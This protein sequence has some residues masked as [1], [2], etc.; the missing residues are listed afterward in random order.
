MTPEERLGAAGF[1]LPAAH[2]IVANYAM[3]VRT[4]PLL[5]V[6]GHGPFVDGQP[7]HVGRLGADLDVEGGRRAA[8][9]V[10]LNLLATVKAELTELSQISRFVKL[11][12]LVN[13]TAEFAEHH[14]VANGATDI[15]VAAFGDLGRPARSAVGVSS[16]PFGFAVEIEAVVAL[17][18]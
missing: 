5:F 1:A 13:A 15:L 2:P 3:T 12:V 6:S 16:L 4:G 7:A 10:I 11:L 8:E 14:L 18:S 9:V 17:Q